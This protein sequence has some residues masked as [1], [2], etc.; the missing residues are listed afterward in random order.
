M[1]FEQDDNLLRAMRWK[2]RVAEAARTLL[3]NPDG[4][5][6]A[7]A[8]VL[9]RDLRVFCYVDRTTHLTTPD[10]RTDVEAMFVAEG[11]RQA[12]LRLC[13]LMELDPYAVREFTNGVSDG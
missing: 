13:E 9:L 2:S 8:R 11:R 3:C 6:N 5:P 10:G 12:Y 1:E 7:S 4:S